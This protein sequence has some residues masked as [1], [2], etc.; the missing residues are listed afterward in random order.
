M[1][2][3]GRVAIVPQD[4]FVYGKQYTR[5]DTVRYRNGIYLAK[6]DNVSQYPTVNKDNDYWM[7]MVRNIESISL[8]GDVTGTSILDEYGNEIVSTNRRGCIV[9]GNIKNSKYWFLFASLELSKS[10]Y[11]SAD[12]FITF[13]VHRVFGSGLIRNFGILTSRLRLNGTGGAGFASLNWEICG[14]DINPSNFKLLYNESSDKIKFE[15]WEKDDVDYSFCHFD[16]LS[17]GLRN[18]KTNNLWTLFNTPDALNI[19]QLPT[20][21]FTQIESTVL[22][23]QNPPSTDAYYS[24]MDSLPVEQR[25]NTFRGKNL[26]NTYTDEQKA[27]VKAGTFKDLFIGDYWVIGGVTW[28]IVDINYWLNTGDTA[29][30]TPHLVIMPD[31]Q[32]YTAPMNDENTTQGGYVGSKMYKEGL[33][34]AKEMVNNAFGSAYILNHREYLTNAVSD[35]HASGGSWFGSR[36]ELPNEIQMYG[37]HI[38]A[39]SGDGTFVPSRYTID[40]TQLALMKMYP[41]FI[42]PA[43]QTQWLRDVVS[44]SYF[45]FVIDGGGAN[46]YGASN[47]SGVRVVFGLTGGN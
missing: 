13:L 9:G 40:K 19:E 21:G 15:L 10:I 2:N 32:L 29:C 24:M 7:Y 4:E 18:A 25:R 44:A 30:T 31:S 47:A 3:A 39:A 36:V 27:Q 42:N 5:L 33:N 11:V 34:Q 1:V 41:R 6:K 22:T 16:V 14:N 12:I 23:L 38:F 28:R 46:T 37:S 8:A 35:G 26:G 45:A 20:E 17:E 43:R